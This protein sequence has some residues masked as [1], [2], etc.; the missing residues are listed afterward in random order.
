M[1]SYLSSSFF[2]T[3]LPIAVVAGG[4]GFVGS[5]VCR[6]LLKKGVRVVCVDNFD[7]G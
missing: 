6:A 5:F 3:D 2:R 7:R 4:G 1:A